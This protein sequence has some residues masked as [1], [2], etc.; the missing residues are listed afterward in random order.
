MKVNPC[1]AQISYGAKLSNNTRK[2]V[3]EF[4]KCYK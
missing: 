4:D 1:Y 3:Q 2:I